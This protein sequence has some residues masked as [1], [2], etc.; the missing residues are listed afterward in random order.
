MKK[1]LTAIILAGAMGVSMLACGSA[2]PQISAATRAIPPVDE[3]TYIDDEAIALAGSIRSA[4]MTE[5]EQLRADELRTMAVS[6]FDLVNAERA[7]RGLTAFTWDGNLELCA[8]IRATEIVGSFSHTRPNNMD[9]YTVNSDLMWAENLAKGYADAASL[10]AGWMASPTHAANILDGELA[11]C[12]IA[13]YEADGTL[14]FAQ[15]FGY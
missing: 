6:A 8:Q 2:A 3:I 11:T 15:E 12:S 1:K 7:A 9:F 10:V 14:Y 4:D 13:V 5:A